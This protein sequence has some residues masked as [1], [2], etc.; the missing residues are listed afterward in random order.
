MYQPIADIDQWDNAAKRYY[1]E[2][3][4]VFI[5]IVTAAAK[6]ENISLNVQNE[7]GAADLFIE[8]GY[9]KK[10]DDVNLLKKIIKISSY[11]DFMR[12]G[13]AVAGNRPALRFTVHFWL[14]LTFFAACQSK[15]TDLGGGRLCRTQS[16]AL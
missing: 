1:K 12:C 4:E 16:S 8:M 3:I 13:A 11:K 2:K 15:P 9:I 14:W 6:K 10:A 5:K 7:N